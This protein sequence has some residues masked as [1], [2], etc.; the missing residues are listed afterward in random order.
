MAAFSSTTGEIDASRHVIFVVTS[1]IKFTTA[2]NER[3]MDG[4]RA[5]QARCRR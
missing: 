4:P 3:A 2:A 5:T 1:S